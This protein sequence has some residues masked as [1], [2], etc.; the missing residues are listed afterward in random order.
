MR[1]ESHGYE[2]L[3]LVSYPFDEALHPPCDEK[4][5]PIHSN[6]LHVTMC[7]NADIFLLNLTSI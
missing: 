5:A 3:S 7:T 6:H 1:L 2:V 4:I